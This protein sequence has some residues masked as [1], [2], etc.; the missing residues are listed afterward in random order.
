MSYWQRSTLSIMKKTT[1]RSY[2]ELDRIKFPGP[3]NY[4]EYRVNA[5][6]K[7]T[8]RPITKEDLY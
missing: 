5:T 4:D 7:W 2:I 6:P 1:P 3:G 8:M